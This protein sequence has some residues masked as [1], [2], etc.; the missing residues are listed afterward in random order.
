MNLAPKSYT[1][2]FGRYYTSACVSDILVASLSIKNP[3]FVLDLGSGDGSLSKAAGKRW[4]RAKYITV[5][6]K[7]ILV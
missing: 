5:D 1:D 6:I 3:Q 4:G 2:P 7:K